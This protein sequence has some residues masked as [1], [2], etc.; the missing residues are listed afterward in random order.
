MSLLERFTA[1][2]APDSCLHCGREGAL[3]CNTCFAGLPLPDGRCFGCREQ[4]GA[5]ACH[6]CLSQRGL[7]SVNAATQ[8]Q[9]VSQQLVGALKFQGNQSAARFMA[10]SMLPLLPSKGLLVHIPATNQHI[11]QRGFDQSAL[12]AREL[13]RLADWRHAALLRRQGSGHQLGSNR[14]ERLV[15]LQ[16]ALSVAAPRAVRGRSIILIDDVLTTGTSITAAAQV[17]LRAGAKEVNVV[18]FAQAGI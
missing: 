1:L 8:Y 12:V 10:Q 7:A 13:A 6:D 18:V 17:L 16:N 3:L 4:I 2:L 5:I 11:R 9:S 14:H 15:G